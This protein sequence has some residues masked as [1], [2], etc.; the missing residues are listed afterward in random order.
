MF[1]TQLKTHIFKVIQKQIHVWFFFEGGGGH[2]GTETKTQVTGPLEIQCTRWK[3]KKNLKYIHYCKRKL[4][5]EICPKATGE[6]TVSLR[7]V[8]AGNNY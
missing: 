1:R 4:N 3:K 8:Q 6:C 5:V 2:K 7:D